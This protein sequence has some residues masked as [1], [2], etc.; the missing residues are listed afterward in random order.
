MMFQAIR[1]HMTYA[2]GPRVLRGDYAGACLMRTFE[3]RKDPGSRLGPAGC[4]EEEICR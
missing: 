4:C 3:K 2:R 1:N